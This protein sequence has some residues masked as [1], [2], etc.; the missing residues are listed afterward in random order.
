MIKIGTK[1]VNK[2]VI[3]NKE[4]LKVIQGDGTSTGILK[5]Q[6][7]GS[8]TSDTMT[9]RVN[10]TY[11]TYNNNN[12]FSSTLTNT[13]NVS[14]SLITFYQLLLDIYNSLN[15]TSYT[16]ISNVK[17]DSL[18]I[19]NKRIVYGIVCGLG[20]TPNIAYD[21]S[22]WLNQKGVRAYDSGSSIATGTTQ[23]TN[24]DWGIADFNLT[25][26]WTLKYPGFITPLYY[27]SSGTLN[28][29]Y[30]ASSATTAT[31]LIVKDITYT[32]DLA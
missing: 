23:Y 32:F 20:S 12:F 16:T 17:I 26:V 15:N 19:Q 31:H 1:K 3:N 27:N 4:V 5:Y 30:T 14:S 24:L 13:N 29:N 10:E 11:A 8:G 21:T 28:Y 2:I 9:L 22:K 25:D 18:T 7:G 6:N